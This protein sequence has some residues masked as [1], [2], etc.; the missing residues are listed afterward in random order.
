LHTM[1]G[2]PAGRFETRHGPFM[3]A[4]DNFEIV[5]MGKGGHAARPHAGSET[6]VA[7]CALVTSLQTIVSRR[8]SPADIAVVSVTDLVTDGTRNVLPGVTRITGDVRSFRPQVSAAIERQL[9]T[10][11][12]GVA[13]AYNLAVSVCYTREFVPLINDPLLADEALEA[14]KAALGSGNAGI[15]PEPYTASEDFARFLELVP[16]CFGFLGNGENSAPLHNPAF[17]FNDEILIPGIA[18]FAAFARRRL[19]LASS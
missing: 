14:A 2:M 3:S 6:L 10:I 1:P 12:D 18:L 8:L 9:G 13:L 11:A 19:P 16:G 7:A 15:H 5:L 4:E 17:D